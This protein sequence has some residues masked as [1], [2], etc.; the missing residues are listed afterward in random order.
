[1][2]PRDS[3]NRPV[4]QR[5]RALSLPRRRSHII[6]SITFFAAVI[7]LPF[8]LSSWIGSPSDAE[9][10]GSVRLETPIAETQIADL[11]LDEALLPDL[12]SDIVPVGENPTEGIERD[13]LGNP[14]DDN[15]KVAASA[16]QPTRSSGSPRTNT[17][18]APPL[19][20][21]LTRDSR[22]G[23]IPGP[24]T[25]G[26]TPLRAYQSQPVPV[27]DRSPVALIVGGLGVQ[28]AL[29]RR[30]IDEL[31][32]EVTLSF[33]AHAPGLQDWID[34]ARAAGHEVLL[35]VPMESETFNANE[36]GADRAMRVGASVSDNRRNLHHLLSRAKGYIGV[37]N[38]N[39]DLFLRRSDVVAPVLAELTASGL[40]FVSDGA[41][42]T[43]SLS[44]LSASVNLPFAEGFGL[45]DPQ[46]D[47]QIIQSRLDALT[48][49]AKDEPGLIG[50]GFAYPQ[51]ID[52]VKGWTATLAAEGL[53]LVPASASLK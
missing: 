40:G 26:L 44:A 2:N 17:L 27:G 33:A 38:Y 13:A 29:T 41:F 7:A 24:N 9:P 52:A 42:D 39:G 25:D 16:A 11:D 5:R 28:S 46:P 30:T 8:L 47:P 14:I 6:A 1:M 37:I 36:P 12:L 20:P 48:I 10:R 45:I 53:I 22:F 18:K 21:S 35:E 43:P 19:D 3:L 23:P 15:P 32:P 31:P 51:T 49:A 34:R 4:T 50:V